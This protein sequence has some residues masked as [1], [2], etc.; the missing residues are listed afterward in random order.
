MRKLREA[1][2]AVAVVGSIGMIG[3]GIAVAQ[4]DGEPPLTSIKCEQD[5]GD[6]TLTNQEG[7]L[8]NANDL[9]SGGDADQRANQQLC[10]LDNE[11]AE[12]TSPTA[13]P[14]DGTTTPPTG[15]GAGGVIGG[16]T[17]GA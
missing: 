5:T 11:N 8:A 12:N 2:A 4:G 17:V 9:L 15:G 16:I 13:P 10:G 6:N 14:T 1:A 7:G 3:A